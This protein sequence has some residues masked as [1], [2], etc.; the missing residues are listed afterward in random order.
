M[1]RIN[2][3]RN[4]VLHFARGACL[5]RGTPNASPESVAV[6]ALVVDSAGARAAPRNYSALARPVGVTEPKYLSGSWGPRTGTQAA[7]S[8]NPHS[9]RHLQK[10]S[11]IALDARYGAESL[12][13]AV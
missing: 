6:I 2:A 11:E 5:D 13:S 4:V 8:P 7:C 12:P 3:A 9:S 1:R 10:P